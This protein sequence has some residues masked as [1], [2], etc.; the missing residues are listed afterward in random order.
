MVIFKF[1]EGNRSVKITLRDHLRMEFEY[2]NLL[3]VN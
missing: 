3:G 2:E 1:V